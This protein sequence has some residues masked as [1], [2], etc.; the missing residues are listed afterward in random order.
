MELT[1]CTL[2]PV[3]LPQFITE[4]CHVM[5]QITGRI[6]HCRYRRMKC[7]YGHFI[8]LF[9]T[10][11]TNVTRNPAKKNCFAGVHQCRVVFEELHNKSRFSLQVLN[12]KETRQRV[13][14]Y[15]KFLMPWMPHYIK[16][17]IKCN[18]FSGKN[19]GFI[20][21]P[22][23]LDFLTTLGR[24][25][26]RIVHFGSICVYVMIIR[27]FITNCHEVTLENFRASVK[28]CMLAKRQMRNRFR[29]KPWRVWRSNDRK[30]ILLCE[31]NGT[32]IRADTEA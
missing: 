19:A 30:Y 31:M 24:C 32:Q 10:F 25:S 14:E 22:Q 1:A 15:H 12:S 23:A 27:E 17:K 7:H 11:N 21:N 5:L 2:I 16:C 3:S 28:F 6:F 8:C 20:R 29:V 13:W 18:K 26:N 9:I 4:R